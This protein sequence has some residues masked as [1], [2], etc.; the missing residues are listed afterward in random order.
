M[1]PN[2]KWKALVILVLVGLCLYGLFFQPKFPP[3]SLADLKSNLQERIRL[4]LDLRGGTHLVLQVQ[5]DDA[6]NIHTD[7]TMDRCR[8]EMR[9]RNLT[10]T[11]VRKLDFTHIQVLGIPPDQ[12]SAFK[13]MVTD[14][15]AEYEWAPTPGD[16]TSYTLSLRPTVVSQIRQD[17]LTQSIESIRRRVDALGV[18]EASIQERGRG[19]WEIL[20]QL[21]GVD[22][23][24]R[25]KGI[26]QE[27]AMLEIRLVREPT[28]YGSQQEALATHGGVLPE[29]TQVLRSVERI[30]GQA[31]RAEAWYIVNRIP[32]VT[33]RDLRS[34]KPSPSPEVPGRWDVDFSL[35]TE[36][37]RRFGPFTAANIGNPLA[38]VLDN[39]IQSV[40][41]IQSRI[42]DS[43]RITGNFTR[44]SANDLA[45]VLRAGA[46]PA[47]IKY[48]EERTVGPSLGADSIRQGFRASLVG[49]TAV[50]IFM[51][52][53]YRAAGI[54]AIVA[55]ILNLI[56]L[57]AAMASIDA[58][59]TLPGIAGV[60]LTVGMGVDSNVLIFERIR[61]E[62]RM[63]KAPVSAV[64]IGFSR[65]FITI[66]DTHVTTV[67][68]C[69]FL[70]MFGSGPVRGFATTLV[71]GLVA[72]VITS[73]WVSRTI[74]DWT[75]GRMPRQAELSI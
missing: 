47:S 69:F 2:L 56:M 40:A 16:S 35:S 38:V 11:E 17:T 48:L 21:P 22:D 53:Y 32:V 1:N 30:S 41:T 52:V 74:F 54:N 6:V 59:L 44:D 39:K 12:S 25:V 26:M 36:G 28:P 75:L 33:G 72:N 8:D 24:A 43:G 42:D 31:G 67:V 19:D 23:P 60:I 68:S 34:A 29:G 50:M 71:I 73:V 62:L 51:L 37:A 15:F 58:V 4:G 9:N 7:Q 46:L 55:L 61:E 27:T 49:I 64:E 65:V 20:V 13:E 70:Y 45:I 14:R 10:Y 66:L 3:K 63:G 18:A 5:V 57:L